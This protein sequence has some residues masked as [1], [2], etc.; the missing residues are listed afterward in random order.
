MVPVPGF[1]L[2]FFSMAEKNKPR[3]FAGSGNNLNL[4]LIL[5]IVRLYPAFF[6]GFGLFPTIEGEQSEIEFFHIASDR[7]KFTGRG[8]RT[9]SKKGVAHVQ[10]NPDFQPRRNCLSHHPYRAA[11]GDSHGC[12]IFRRR[13]RFASC[14]ASR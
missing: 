5:E 4:F 13:C 2:P 11:D 3:L 8:Y 7:I 14:P 10:K 1:E 12:G 6:E 9:C